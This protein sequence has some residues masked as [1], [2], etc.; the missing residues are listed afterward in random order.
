MKEVI[1]HVVDDGE[2]LEVHE[3]WA[4]NIVCGFAR[5][6]GHPVGVVGNSRAH[7]PACSTSTRR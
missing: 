5:L 4:D 6:G 2:F 1:R 3:R 7:W